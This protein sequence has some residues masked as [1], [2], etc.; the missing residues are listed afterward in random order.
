M[1]FVAAL[2]I[3][4]ITCAICSLAQARSAALAEAIAPLEQDVPQVAIVRLRALLAQTLAPEERNAAIEKLAEALFASEQPNEALKILSDPALTITPEVL[5]LRAQALGALNRWA[6]A[7]PIYQQVASTD[8]PHRDAAAMGAADALR[9][10]GRADE[11]LEMLGRLRHVSAWSVRAALRIAELQLAKSDAA[12]ASR[13]LGLVKAQSASERREKRLLR[14]RAEAE[15]GH[16]DKALELFATILKKPEGAPHDVLLAALFG[17]ADL[18]LRMNT[19]ESGDDLVE[20]YIEHRPNDPG[21]PRVFDKLDQLYNAER[22]ASLRELTRWTIDPAQPRRALAQWHLARMNLRAGRR[23][24]AMHLFSQLRATRL[25]FPPLAEAFLE[26]AQ[27]AFED[28]NFESAGAI[29]SDGRALKPPAPLL[30]RIESLQA[31]VDYGAHNERAA[32]EHFEQIAHNGGTAARDAIFNASIAWL[33][34][35]DTSRFL[36]D[37]AEFAA[38]GG[39]ENGR[40]D[41]LLEQG[42]AQ[43]K[44]ND[45]AATESLRQFTRDFSRHP[46]VS[47]AWVALAELAFHSS[48]PRV[49]EAQQFLARAAESRPNAAAAERADYLRIWLADAAPDPNAPGTIAL[50]NEFLQ[51]HEG[52]PFITDV[53]MKLAEA[54]FRR[55]DFANAQT[56]FELL[57]QK[58]PTAPLAEKAQFFAAESALQTMAEKSLDRALLLLNEVVKRNGELK[59]AA[60]NEQALVERKLGK[61]EDALTL[62]DE[63]LNGDAK[64]TE[65]REALCGKADVIYEQA[66]NDHE[67]YRTAHDLYR[68]LASEPDVPIHWRNQALFKAGMCLEKMDDRPQA[69][70]TFYRVI[71]NE[72]RPDKPREFFWFYKAGFNAARLLE[73]Q[74]Q[75]AS[76]ASVYQKLSLAG[77]ERT[78]EAKARLAQLRLEHFLWEQ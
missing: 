25:P 53:R 33:Q 18:H 30:E 71:E 16:T 10:L 56:Q 21:L 45:K 63:V 58:A 62:Y 7:L 12:A 50:A 78:D 9:A 39:D 75:W 42:L 13:T 74:S 51:K 37:A 15:L 41:L 14:A 27:L 64:A 3:S 11:A 46:R 69:L 6:E 77:G 59:W 73:E 23:D 67:K 4:A 38:A 20:E 5:F 65:K 8:S 36:V 72:G 32:A 22:K 49:S 43:A 76:A 55:Q 26:F 28:R 48:P 66:S 54:Y 57:V 60:R 17:S 61:P 44:Q 70:D 2:L 31:R 68:Q 40:A 24:N 52:S 34:A 35:R 19:P 1:K 47:E 29:L